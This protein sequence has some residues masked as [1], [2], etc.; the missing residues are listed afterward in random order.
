MPA[1]IATTPTSTPAN[2][3]AATPAAS[4]QRTTSAA[5]PPPPSRSAANSYTDH[6]RP[7]S[8]GRDDEG[9]AWQEGDSTTPHPGS[10]PYPKRDS[11]TTPWM[12][13][14]WNYLCS[15]QK[16]IR[17]PFG[18]MLTFRVEH[19]RERG[20]T[21]D[22]GQNEPQNA[23]AD[24]RARWRSNFFGAY[25]AGGWTLDADAESGWPG[26][27]R[28]GAG[29]PVP[30]YDQMFVHRAPDGILVPVIMQVETWTG[31]QA[32]ATPFINAVRHFVPDGERMPVQ[33]PMPYCVP[34]W[35]ARANG[36]ASTSAMH[37]GGKHGDIPIEKLD[38]KQIP[39]GHGGLKTM[40][41]VGR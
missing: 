26:W 20:R 7:T 34:A 2:A 5:P 19:G 18:T 40:R 8:S 35:L 39:F 31:T 14:T 17:W 3:P 13:G 6:H 29:I 25:A 36:W 32:G 9:V 4:A 10:E 27:E 1:K 22:W 37:P 15:I 12:S 38:Y 23:D 33:A 16:I 30:P 11:F 41:D 28:N 21:F 24:K